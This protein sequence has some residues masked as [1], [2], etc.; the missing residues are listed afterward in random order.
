MRAPGGEEVPSHPVPDATSQSPPRQTQT[1]T[2]YG[3]TPLRLAPAL[4]PAACFLRWRSDGP[5]VHR[6]V[7]D[8][9][10]LGQLPCG[11]RPNTHCAIASET[12]CCLHRVPWLHG[13][14]RGVPPAGAPS[15]AATPHMQ[16]RLLTARVCVLIMYLY[17]RVCTSY[18]HTFAH[19]H[20]LIHSQCPDQHGA[21][22]C[23]FTR[24]H[25][26]QH[27]LPGFWGSTV[28]VRETLWLIGEEH[29]DL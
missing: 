19:L 9:P 18:A 3:P 20:A 4:G 26:H 15:V 11:V 28:R 23:I 13:A 6:R 10:P 25:T 24:G 7:S 5:T 17:T 21:L 12:P 1:W 16:Q 29:F 2:P 14:P 27:L 22:T 8:R